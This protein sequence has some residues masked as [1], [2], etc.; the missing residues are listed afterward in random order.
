MIQEQEFKEDSQ[1]CEKIKAEF[2]GTD[3]N[4]LFSSEMRSE[5]ID[6]CLDSNVEQLMNFKEYTMSQQ[7]NEQV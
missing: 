3:Y 1:Q 7:F 5:I 4:F 6:N 2:F